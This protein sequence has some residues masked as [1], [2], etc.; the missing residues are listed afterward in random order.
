VSK[1]LEHEKKRKGKTHST[2]R[3]KE[4]DIK[5]VTKEEKF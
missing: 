5:C 2:K 4:K 3:K 1:I